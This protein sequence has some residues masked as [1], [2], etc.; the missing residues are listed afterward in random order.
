MQN[1]FTEACRVFEDNGKVQN[2]GWAKKLLLDY[3][4]DG[5][6]SQRDTYFVTS[7]ECSMY[8]SI[9]NLGA[10]FGI[11]IAIADLKRG[12]IIC[13]SVIQKR[14]V[15]KKPLP[16]NADNGEFEFERKICVLKLPNCRTEKALNASLQA[17]AE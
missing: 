15:M 6:H 3:N 2:A 8:L 12:G 1:E 16:D 13:D 7:D 17:L 11:K 14:R 9:E 10:D 4:I 5:R